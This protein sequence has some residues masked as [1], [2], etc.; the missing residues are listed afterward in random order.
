MWWNH[1][2][3]SFD[4]RCCGYDSS[5]NSLDIITPGHDIHHIYKWKLKMITMLPYY[6]KYWIVSMFYGF[7]M[8]RVWVLWVVINTI[9]HIAV[10]KMYHP[11]ERYSS[12]VGGKQNC[13]NRFPL[14]FIEQDSYS[15]YSLT[16]MIYRPLNWYTWYS[17]CFTILLLIYMKTL[18]PQ[19]PFAG[20]VFHILMLNCDIYQEIVF[21]CV[22]T[23]SYPHSIFIWRY[24]DII[25]LQILLWLLF[26]LIYA[27]NSFHRWFV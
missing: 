13:E 17:L 3:H 6:W 22:M 9:T 2:P 10:I 23:Y 11:I 8:S 1:H 26:S 21:K 12:L 15:S 4:G 20:Q 16:P 19:Y 5:S 7:L 14:W 18:V 25:R 24:N 27:W